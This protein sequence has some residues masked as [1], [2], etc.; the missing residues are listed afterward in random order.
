[1]KKVWIISFL[2]DDLEGNGY[3]YVAKVFDNEEKAKATYQ[4]PLPSRSSCKKEIIHTFFIFTP[5]F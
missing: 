4:Y 1:M 2:Q 5:F 3:W